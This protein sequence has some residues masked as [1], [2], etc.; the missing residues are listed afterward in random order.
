L[1]QPKNIISS[2]YVPFW[3][4]RFINATVIHVF[5]FKCS[6]LP[7]VSWKV[8]HACGQHLLTFLL[9][10]CLFWQWPHN[11]IL[12]TRVKPTPE[13]PRFRESQRYHLTPARWSLLDQ[14]IWSNL[15]ISRP[16]TVPSW[17]LTSEILG[18]FAGSSWK[19]TSPVLMITHVEHCRTS[20][21]WMAIGCWY[22]SSSQFQGGKRKILI[23]SN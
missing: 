4:G 21:C 18:V 6:F 19:F 13:S 1:M 17:D 10:M 23:T 14:A 5:F 11:D 22:L 15:N 16:P 9:V 12:P 3:W 20:H 7:W 8:G 2:F